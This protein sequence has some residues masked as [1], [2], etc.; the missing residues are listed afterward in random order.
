MNEPVLWPTVVTGVT[1]TSFGCHDITN[2]S[3]MREK[4]V[5][6]HRTLACDTD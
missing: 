4:L 6:S 1:P 5:A 2:T 3:T